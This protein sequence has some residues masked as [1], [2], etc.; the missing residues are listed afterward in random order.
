[1]GMGA[2]D[3][4]EIVWKHYQRLRVIGRGL[5]TR[6]RG[7]IFTEAVRILL[8]RICCRCMK[9]EK[10]PAGHLRPYPCLASAGCAD[11]KYKS[12]RI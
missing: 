12:E 7:D 10:I 9:K 6:L 3:P 1:M 8:K 11:I 2:D 5:E 4:P